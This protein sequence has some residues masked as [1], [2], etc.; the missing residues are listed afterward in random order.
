MP[1]I[2]IN[3]EVFCGKCGAGLCRNTDVT[4]HHGQ[5]AFTVEPCQRCL[6]REYEVGYEAGK[7][8]TERVKQGGDMKDEDR[9]LLTEAMGECWHETILRTTMDK[10]WLNVCSCGANTG[11]NSTEKHINDSNRTFDNWHDFGVLWEWA[12]KQDWWLDMVAYFEGDANFRAFCLIDTRMIDPI[13]FAE[14]IVEKL[15]E[16]KP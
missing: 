4:S 7:A 5:D 8:D 11:P 13:K 10:C 2:T 1:E 12:S 14:A 16:A 9:K 3:V 15:K 6:D